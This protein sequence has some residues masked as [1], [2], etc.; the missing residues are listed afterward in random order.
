MV[1][2]DTEPKAE[3]PGIQKR[4]SPHFGGECP[5]LKEAV[6]W[7]EKGLRGA[8]GRERGF[9]LPLKQGRGGWGILHLADTPVTPAP[10]EG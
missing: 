4:W 7:N 1:W 3:K 10:R 6:S 5:R 2:G 9:G 8:E